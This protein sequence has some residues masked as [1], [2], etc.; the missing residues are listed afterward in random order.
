MATLTGLYS[1]VFFAFSYLFLTLGI[2]VIFLSLDCTFLADLQN[3]ARSNLVLAT[4]LAVFLFSLAGIP[5]LLGFFSKY[6][7]FVG[8]LDL[9]LYFL[10][11]VVVIV[12][13]F[14]TFYYLRILK[15]AFIDDCLF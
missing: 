15:L 14:S 11:G 12:S 10:G 6:L 2:W 4:S 7:V 9:G 8:L 5:P 1:F 13:C 3:L